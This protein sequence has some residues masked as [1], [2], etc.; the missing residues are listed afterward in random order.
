[1]EFVP[2]APVDVSVEMEDER[3][4]V[5]DAEQEVAD[6]ADFSLALELGSLGQRRCRRDSNCRC[7]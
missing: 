6:L 2:E 7:C 1:M 3:K 5:G 4:A